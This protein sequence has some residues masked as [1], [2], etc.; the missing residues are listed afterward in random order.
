MER[1]LQHP[2]ILWAS[3]IVLGLIFIVASVDK[4]AIPEVFAA[5]VAAYQLVPVSLVNV[6]ALVIPWIELTCG[7]F[8][9]AGVRLRASSAALSGLLLVFI[10]AITISI[11][12]GLNIDCGCFGSSHATPVGWNKVIE[13]IGMLLLGLHLFFFSERKQEQQEVAAQ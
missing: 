2:A 12:R 1:I 11:F 8:L 7:L 10:G 6:V 3:R 9:V 4:I 13:D 5:N